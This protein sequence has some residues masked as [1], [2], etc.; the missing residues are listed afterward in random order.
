MAGIEDDRIV[1]HQPIQSQGEDGKRFV[2]AEGTTQV[3]RELKEHLGFFSG[4]WAIEARKSSSM[5][6]ASADSFDLGPFEAG[7]R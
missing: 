6:L 7:R 1:R 4:P 2:H 5:P 3:S